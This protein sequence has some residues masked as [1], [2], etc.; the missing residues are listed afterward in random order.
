MRLELVG[1]GLLLDGDEPEA[2]DARAYAECLR[3]LL[4]VLALTAHSSARPAIGTI[5]SEVMTCP[6][7]VVNAVVLSME[8]RASPQ[9]TV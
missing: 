1:Q 5:A 4:T 8:H 6:R 2:A 3:R 9:W 7:L